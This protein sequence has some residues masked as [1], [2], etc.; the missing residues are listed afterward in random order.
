MIS[1]ENAVI[2]ACLTVTLAVALAVESM[3]LSYP[4][5]FPLA[6]FVGGGVVVPLAINE[7]LDRREEAAE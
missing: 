6:L 3:S 1:R 4:G 5:W 7:M 2:V